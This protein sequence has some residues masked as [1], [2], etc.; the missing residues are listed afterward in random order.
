MMQQS[1]DLLQLSRPRFW[2]YLA[3]PFVIGYLSGIHEV[4]EFNTTLFWLYLLY[5]LV[6]A[7]IFLYGVNDL[8]DG[9]TDQFNDKK[10]G[11]EATL[12]TEAK[13]LLTAVLWGCVILTLV[14]AYISSSLISTVILV[15]FLFL[16]YAYSQKPFRWKAQPVI[17]SASN[18][19]YVL[20]GI[21]G[22]SV[23]SGSLPSLWIILSCGFWTA[24]MHLFSAIPDIKADSL[25]NLK[26]T[27][28]MLGQQKAL[29]W[30]SALW[31]IFA[32]S[33]YALFEL[34]W[35][36]PVFI[37]PLMPII[38]VLNITSPSKLYKVFPYLNAAVGFFLFWSIF[39]HK[40]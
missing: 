29:L 15:A 7:N 20:P 31:L 38:C 28:V 11:Y 13:K 36:V 26:T 32:V 24:A 37:Y 6:P 30:C 35:L 22:Y 17:D 12:Q 10:K 34:W 25:A 3:G 8:A 33:I 1:L 27:A 14:L 5:F 4:S 2:L 19:L 39:L 16:S 9:D 18:I 23:S 21:L 40:F